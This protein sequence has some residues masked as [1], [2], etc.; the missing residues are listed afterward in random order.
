MWRQGESCTGLQ[1][2]VFQIKTRPRTPRGRPS[3]FFSMEDGTLNGD[4]SGSDE[5]DPA[6]AAGRGGAGSRKK[7]TLKAG[8]GV[9][10]VVLF[11]YGLLSAASGL[12]A[13]RAYG[14]REWNEWIHRPTAA[15]VSRAEGRKLGGVLPDTNIFGIACDPSS[16]FQ[17]HAV[18][19]AASAFAL[20]AGYAHWRTE[21]TEESAPRS[22]TGVRHAGTL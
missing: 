9:A 12:A 21:H 14:E 1:F 11:G 15:P 13:G 6:P 8:L 22:L 17:Q 20:L 4:G 18:W 10:A 7:H 19:H 16:S 2:G 5:E 3:S